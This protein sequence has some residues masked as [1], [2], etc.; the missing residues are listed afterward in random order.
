MDHDRIISHPQVTRFVVK[1]MHRTGLLRQS[2]YVG[3]VE[4]DDDEATGL[5]AMD[6]GL[7]NGY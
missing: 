7:K 1:S 2:Q 6:L 5:A 3:F 4:A